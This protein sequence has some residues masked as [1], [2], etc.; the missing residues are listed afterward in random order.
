MP[1]FALGNLFKTAAAKRWASECRI[2]SIFFVDSDI[3]L[4]IISIADFHFFE[5]D[6]AVQSYKLFINI[7]NDRRI[8]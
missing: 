8:C 1:S 5:K 3:S 2:L 4:L 6:L 7:S